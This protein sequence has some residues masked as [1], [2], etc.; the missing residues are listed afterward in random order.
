VKTAIAGCEPNWGRVL[1]AAGNSGIAFDP[2]KVDIH[3]QK[4]LVCERGVAADFEEEELK[5]KLDAPEV[6]VRFTIRGR[7]AGQAR[8]WTCDLT[9]KYI[10]INASY[11]T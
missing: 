6:R 3:L 9:E 5:Y 8:F 10:E 2:A 4:T 1:S 11:R 7:G